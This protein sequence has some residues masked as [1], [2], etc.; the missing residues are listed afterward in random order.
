MGGK[1]K[2]ACDETEVSIIEKN[3]N[4]NYFLTDSVMKSIN[5]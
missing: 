3:K 4:Q 1:N 2:T 5:N